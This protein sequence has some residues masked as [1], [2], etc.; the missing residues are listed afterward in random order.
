MLG[1]AYDAQVMVEAVE[2]V[3]EVVRGDVFAV[4]LNMLLVGGGAQLALGLLLGVMGDRGV[5]GVEV[6]VGKLVR[7][8]AV[9]VVQNLTVVGEVQR[10]GLVTDVDTPDGGVIHKGHGGSLV[11]VHGVDGV[12]LT[13]ARA[14]SAPPEGND[15]GHDGTHAVLVEEIQRSAILAVHADDEINAAFGQLLDVGLGAGVGAKVVYADVQAASV[16]ALVHSGMLLFK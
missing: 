11:L 6:Q 9:H 13:R 8:G 4:S 2:V 10:G 7:E 12:H 16:H 5:V 15:V 14:V 3:G 1:H